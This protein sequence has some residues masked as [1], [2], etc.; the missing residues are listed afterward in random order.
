MKGFNRLRNKAQI[1]SSLADDHYHTRLMHSL[2][3]E[4]I[5]TKI[6]IQLKL[7]KTSP[8]FSNIDFDKLSVISLLHDIGHT[9]Y[10]HIGERTI[11]DICIGRIQINNIPNFKKLKV[12]C[13]FKHNINSAILYKEHLLKNA[14]T[15][16][17]FDIDVLDG[18]MKHTSIYYKRQ[19]RF[20][21]GFEYVN[22]GLFKTITFDN[23][24]AT[25]EGLI[26][27]VADE[28]AQVCSDYSDLY[29][30]G[31]NI[32][33]FKATKP[34]AHSSSLDLNIFVGQACDYLVSLLVSSFN[35][36]SS[37]ASIM[38]S[39]F[40]VAIKD[41]DKCRKKIIKSDTVISSHDNIKRQYTIELFKYYFIN[42]FNRDDIKKDY[43]NRIK[44]LKVHK[45]VLK[46]TE[47]LTL[48]KVES[49]FNQTVKKMVAKPISKSFTRN[50][51]KSYKALYRMYIRTIAIHVS[52]MTDSY[53]NHK[54][55]KIISTR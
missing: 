51:K 14:A 32:K 17:S 43:F 29:L 13:G 1:F 16:T 46:E 6:A 2:E 49:F 18:I 48:D 3:V 27:A 20:D 55:D 9:P 10:G 53:A 38:K 22:A 8:K 15:I 26:V 44:R 39:G 4:A 37:Y 31:L 35:S 52:K 12:S 54:I 50:C 34:F 36:R 23:K 30:S 33:D 40:G 47:S 11:H 21:Y 7:T 42:G 45:D 24:P 28:I 5:A 25:L 19:K 41:F